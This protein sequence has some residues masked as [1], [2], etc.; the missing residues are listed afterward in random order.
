MHTGPAYWVTHLAPRRSARALGYAIGWLTSGA[1]LFICSG[2]N[3]YLSEILM[4]I[5]EVTHADFAAERWQT[6]LVYV[7]VCLMNLFVNLPK[8]LRV[9]HWTVSSSIVIYN[10]TAALLLI[11]LLVLA[12]PKQSA[13][14]VFRDVVNK[15]GWD[16]VPVVFFISL[17][18]GMAAIGGFDS[19]THLTDEV[20]HPGKNVPKVMIGAAIMNYVVCL[21]AII[22]YLFCIVNPEGLLDPVGGQP[23]VQLLVD[24]YKLEALSIVATSLILLSFAI[25]GW[26]CLTSFSRLYWS[27]SRHGGF[28]FSKFTARLSP[29]QK[30]PV[31]ALLVN[32]V[33]LI[34]I[35]AIQIGSTIALNALLGGGVLCSTTSFGIVFGLLL[36]RGRVTLNPSRWLN[37]GRFGLA[38]DIFALIWCAWVSVWVCFPLY[39]PV[40][41]LSMNWTCVVAFGLAAIS[42]IYYFAIFR[43]TTPSDVVLVP[44]V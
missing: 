11:A 2:S 9:V 22:I 32:T 21:A 6:Y 16:S 3:L 35:G 7:G 34:A 38:L 14:T 1:W 33:M 44:R 29:S 39:V 19:A 15:T 25:G 30:I 5:V 36:W 43:R 12:N 41:P 40:T 20:P 28:P 13:E 42:F 37:L 24:G 8:N 31:N 18:P 23:L 10:G 17:L 27:F 4:A 26:A